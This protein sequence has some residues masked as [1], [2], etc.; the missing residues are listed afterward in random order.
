MQ[1]LLLGLAALATAVAPRVDYAPAALTE[2][3]AE[4]GGFAAL[5]R[6]PAFRRLMLLAALILG[7]HALHDGFAV[8]RWR[9]AGIDSGTIGLLWSEAVAAEVVV[10]LFIGPPVLQRF[11]PAQVIAFVAVMGA[12]RWIVEGSTVAVPAMALIQPIHGLTFALLHLTAMRVLVTIVPAEL[13]GTAQTFYS[14]VGVALPS[15]LLMLASG[16][17]FDRFGAG[18]FYVMAALALTAAALARGLR[19]PEPRASR[20]ASWRL[21]AR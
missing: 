18:G 1:A 15:A 12:V 8:I 19:T 7:S 11:A 20:A 9:A 21:R 4:A 13:A 5:L 16:M 3:P 10:F 6:L 14:T 2:T 17:L